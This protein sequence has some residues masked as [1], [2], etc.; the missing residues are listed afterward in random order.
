MIPKYRSARD[1]GVAGA[2]GKSDLQMLHDLRFEYPK[3]LLCGYLNINSLRNKINDLR[4]ILHNVPLDYFV[5]RETKLDKSFPNAQ[6]TIN[7]YKITLRR[8]RDKHGG[9]LIEFVRKGLICKRLRKYESLNVEVICSEVTI[10]NKNWVIFSIYRPPHYS[11]LLAF[12]KE[13]GKYLNQ[14]CENYDNFIVMGDFN[15]DIRQTSQE[16]HKLDE[17]CSLFSQTNIIKSDT[18]FTKFH[19]SA[20]DFF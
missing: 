10:S 11:N 14:A 4:L 12:F 20:I 8:D 2:T 5:I 7:N 9:G 3:N 6:L 13:L 16:S 17:H 18:C 15:I 1:S 19:S